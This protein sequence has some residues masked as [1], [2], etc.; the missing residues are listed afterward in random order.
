MTASL[1]DPARTLVDISAREVGAAGNGMQMTDGGTNDFVDGPVF[2]NGKD[3][4]SPF[5][6][7]SQFFTFGS[8][9]Q[10][11]GAVIRPKYNFSPN[12][13][14]HYVDMQSQAKDSATVQR[15]DGTLALRDVRGNALSP[16]VRVRFVSS[17]VSNTFEAKVFTPISGSA[18]DL[19]DVS[20]PTRASDLTRP[21]F[22]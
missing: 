7:G 13:F 21:I 22:E 8:M 14:G 1:V 15:I 17:S 20:N 10:E 2:K 12:S 5:G 11:P 19:S 3:K 18:V 4:I 16:A 9:Q 6:S